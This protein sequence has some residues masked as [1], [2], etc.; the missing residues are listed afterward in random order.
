MQI[1]VRLDVVA[2]GYALAV[3]VF[4]LSLA[5]ASKIAYE[6]R[7][8]GDSGSWTA[9]SFIVT[10]LALAFVIAIITGAIREMRDRR[11]G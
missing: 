3:V 11:G 5:A 1:N 4:C 2:V 10:P 6:T 8:L 9:L 7:G